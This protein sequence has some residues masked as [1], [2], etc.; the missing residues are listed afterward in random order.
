MKMKKNILDIILVS[1][2]AL[3]GCGESE[4]AAIDPIGDDIP[5][6][7]EK[8]EEEMAS[9]SSQL[10]GLII[11]TTDNAEIIG[12]SVS[13]LDPET[14]KQKELFSFHHTVTVDEQK[15]GADA[16]GHPSSLYYA[17]Y[18]HW[19][20]HDFSKMAVT[21]YLS[22][23]SQHAGWVD[24]NGNFFDVT[25]AL[26]MQSQSDFD[27][28]VKFSSIG[29]SEDGAYFS[30]SKHIDVE[31]S[32]YGETIHYY[33]PVSDVSQDAVA[34]GVMIQNSAP[35]PYESGFIVAGDHYGGLYTYYEVTDWI[36][37]HTCIA[38]V[39]SP[40]ETSLIIDVDTDERTEY[41]PGTSRSNWN[42]VLSPDGTKVAFTSSPLS[43]AQN[44]SIYI[45]PLSGGEPIKIECNFYLADA[46]TCRETKDFFHLRNEKY[47]SML[48][49]WK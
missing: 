42:G 24:S 37:S 33:I 15:K 49:D 47:C 35:F 17:N 13:S 18:R 7:Y 9:N 32:T 41:I 6:Q 27:D 26:G 36:D 31:G 44:P 45:V 2:L 14:G 20:N 3:V 29:F 39:E 40:S 16:Y 23:G 21:R 12:I 46:Y 43:G 38:N 4:T 11:M 5:T 10:S 8:E 1:C 30:F 48:I 22:T 25:E 19:F 28:P 34:E